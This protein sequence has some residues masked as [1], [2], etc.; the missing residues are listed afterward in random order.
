[1]KI[2]ASL[3]LN[4]VKVE[5]HKILYDDGPTAA[6]YNNKLQWSRLKT[7]SDSTRQCEKNMLESAKRLK[8]FLKKKKR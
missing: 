2:S 4:H 7:F 6:S 3:G 8:S 5:R 1:M